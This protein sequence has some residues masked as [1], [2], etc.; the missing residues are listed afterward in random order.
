MN[1]EKICAECKKNKVSESSPL[2]ICDECLNN[3]EA[4]LK[5]HYKRGVENLFA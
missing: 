2:T 1:K 3:I 4:V 5:N